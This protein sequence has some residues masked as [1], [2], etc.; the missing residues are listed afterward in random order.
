MKCLNVKKFYKHAYW[1][2]WNAL[3]KLSSAQIIMINFMD[4]SPRALINLF[5]KYAFSMMFFAKQVAYN[6][7]SVLY[8]FN[9]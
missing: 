8:L 1:I 5:V 3:L 6:F 2:Y 4:G 9:L 7:A